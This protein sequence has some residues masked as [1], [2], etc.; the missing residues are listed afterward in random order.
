MTA[1]LVC[2]ICM[3]TLSATAQRKAKDRYL[4]RKV[5]VVMMEEQSDK[6]KQPE[7]FEDEITFRSN[8][9]GSRQMQR[10]EGFQ[11][12]EYIVHDRDTVLEETQFKFEGI[13]KNSKDMSLKWEGSVYGAQIE[14]T[15]I[16]SKNGKIKQEFE[17]TGE[18]KE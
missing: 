3:M 8:K 18:L 17:F 14:G 15:A 13:N 6:R 16:I 7:P 10:D 2:A 12:G 11:S 5:F 4:D 1:V 9:M